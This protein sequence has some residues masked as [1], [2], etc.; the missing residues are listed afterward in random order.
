MFAGKSPTFTASQFMATDAIFKF[1]DDLP[2]DFN[3]RDS[4]HKFEEFGTFL[5]DKN[6]KRT[7]KNTAMHGSMS[8]YRRDGPAAKVINSG[9]GV[10][11]AQVKKLNPKVT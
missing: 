9:T 6:R 3:K 5:K 11:G 10:S 8:Y 7:W 2:M 1:E 4:I